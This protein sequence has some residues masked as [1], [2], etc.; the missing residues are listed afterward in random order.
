MDVHITETG[1]GQ[2]SEGPM[3]VVRKP[4]VNRVIIGERYLC[5]IMADHALGNND[6]VRSIPQVRITWE[7]VED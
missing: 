6:G 3:R 7:E 5:D 4:G 2:I 1:N